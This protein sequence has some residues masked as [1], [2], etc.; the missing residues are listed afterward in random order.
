[1]RLEGLST[2]KKINSPHL[3]LE[4][5]IFRLVAKCL[6]QLLYRVSTNYMYVLPLYVIL[7]ADSTTL[8]GY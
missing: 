8:C 4:T 5:V 1:M 2:L 7:I 3:G 6:N